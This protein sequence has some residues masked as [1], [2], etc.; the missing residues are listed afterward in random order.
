MDIMIQS[1]NVERFEQFC[2]ILEKVS[3]Y[4]PIVNTMREQLAVYSCERNI[5]ENVK[6]ESL[7]PLLE[8]DDVLTHSEAR[9]LLE[10]GEPEKML[11]SYLSHKNADKCSSFVNCLKKDGQHSLVRTI[12]EKVNLNAKKK[13]LLFKSRDSGIFPQT[14]TPVITPTPTGTP[15]NTP[16]PVQASDVAD[17]FSRLSIVKEK[18]LDFNDTLGM[19]NDELD[20]QYGD[21]LQRLKRHYEE[22]QLILEGKKNE[23]QSLLNQLYWSQK[24]NLR[25][26]ARRKN[27]H[28]QRDQILLKPEAY[29]KVMIDDS[30]MDQIRGWD[31]PVIVGSAHY[32]TTTAQGLGLQLAYT[33][34]TAVFTVEFRDIQNHLLIAKCTED[35]MD[36]TSNFDCVIIDSEN[37]LVPS[38]QQILPS[39]GWV[40]GIMTIAYMPTVTGYLDISV[41]CSGHQ[42]TSSPFKVFT[43]PLCEYYKLLTTPEEIL[44]TTETITG[45]TLTRSGDAAICTESGKLYIVKHVAGRYCFIDV[46]AY[47]GGLSLNLPRGISCDSNDNLVVA[48]TRNLQLIKASCPEVKP[49]FLKSR[50]LK[51]EPTCVAAHDRMVAAGGSRDV[52]IC[53]HDLN[54]LHTVTF[55]SSLSALTITDNLSIHVAVSETFDNSHYNHAC[56]ES[57]DSKTFQT[58]YAH[59]TPSKPTSHKYRI[60]HIVTDEEHNIIVCYTAQSVVAM[61]NS[62]GDLLSCYDNWGSGWSAEF[63]VVAVSQNSGL[64]LVDQTKNKLFESHFDQNLATYTAAELP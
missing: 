10:N 12:K 43:Y 17:G 34:K 48:N 28:G 13:K 33:N 49:R 46:A 40:R 3:D 62:N 18:G 2:D 60:N 42:I 29:M 16:T 59:L 45:L 20:E 22:M 9:E 5:E 4:G 55:S 14:P 38:K 23:A 25:K 15:I 51:F 7:V 26:D 47:H 61:F 44:S 57:I 6:L 32:S 1:L 37:S 41:K 52:I 54:I 56:I 58:R 30:V 27:R 53:D 21:E 24:D 8:N 35:M 63:S 64:L 11:L 19:I 39:P 36:L 31:I 50:A